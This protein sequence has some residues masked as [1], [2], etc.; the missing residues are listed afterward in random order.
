MQKYIPK[1]HNDKSIQSMEPS[2]SK[3][4]NYIYWATAG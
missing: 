2:T 3:K 1:A 4:K